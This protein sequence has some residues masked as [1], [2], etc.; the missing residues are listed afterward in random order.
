MALDFHYNHPQSKLSH[1]TFAWVPIPRS[2]SWHYISASISVQYN[3]NTTTSL[4]GICTITMGSVHL[5][6]WVKQQYKEIGFGKG[7]GGPFIGKPALKQK[8]IS[9]YPMHKERIRQ[10]VNA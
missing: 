6:S 10:L 9:R 3:I 2:T 4:Y 7:G 5:E 1:A 8:L